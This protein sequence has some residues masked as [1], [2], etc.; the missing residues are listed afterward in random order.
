MG[1]CYT[2]AGEGAMGLWGLLVVKE[3]LTRVSWREQ[4]LWKVDKGGEG[5][6]GLVVAEIASDDLLDVDAGGMVG[7]NKGNPITVAGRKRGN[8]DR[9]AGDGSDLV[10]SSVDN[11]AGESLVKEE[12]GHFA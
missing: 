8:E 7:K 5:E 1:R 12:G 11:G 4:S 9:S 3:E 6:Y 2:V 10:E